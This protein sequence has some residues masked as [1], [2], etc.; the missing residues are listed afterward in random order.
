LLLYQL[1]R[2]LGPEDINVLHAQASAWFAENGLIEEAIKH[3]MTGEN[4][5]AA[6]QL[7]VK[8]GFDL[9]NDVQWPR[10]KRWL[11]MLPGEIV[12]Q[13]PELLVLTSWLH[14]IYSRYPELESCL[15]KAEA[16][17]NSRKVE[18]YVVG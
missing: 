7:I 10:L 6:A 3:A 4:S 5:E 12:E 13:T 17:Y 15:N 2:R 11:G 9:L 14:Q 18:E 1:K 8:Y 16:L